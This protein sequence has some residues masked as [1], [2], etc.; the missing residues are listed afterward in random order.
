M[1]L[2][3]FFEANEKPQSTSQSSRVSFSTSKADYK[4]KVLASPN[5]EL[6]P[7]TQQFALEY[8]TYTEHTGAVAALS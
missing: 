4:S 2:L 5:L 3:S 8:K 1:A 7:F 6:L